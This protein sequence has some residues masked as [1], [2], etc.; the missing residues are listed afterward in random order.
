MSPIEIT[1]TVI[2]LIAQIEQR[3]PAC[4][5]NPQDRDNCQGNVTLMIIAEGGQMFGQMF[6]DNKARRR[7]TCR[8]AWHKA[9]QVWMTG[10][11]TGQFERRV[12]GEGVDPGQF[13]LTHPELVGWD[14]GL[15]VVASDGTKFAVAMSG[16]TGVTDCRIIR[17]A[18]AAVPGLRMAE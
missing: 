14:G 18:V 4:M 8:T 7:G 2:Q 1:S 6:G 17:E 10:Q 3:I 15:P 12:Y 5:Q 13:G 16:F 11:A 9:T